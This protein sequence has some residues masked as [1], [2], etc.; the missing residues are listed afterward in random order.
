MSCRRVETAVR[1]MSTEAFSRFEGELFHSIFGLI[2]SPVL[3]DKLGGVAAL[4]ALINASTCQAEIKIIKFS[5]NLS[6][7]LRSN[8]NYDLLVQVSKALGHM[9]SSRVV[10]NADFVEFEIDRGLEWLRAEQWR[11]RLAACL[12]LK[13]LAANTP[14][15]FYGKMGDFLQRITP[16]L[17]D[18][19]VNVRIASTEAVT[20]CLQILA[21]RRLRYHLDWLCGIYD[22]LQEGM[23]RASEAD[24]HGAL[25]AVEAMLKHCKD[26]MG[27]RFREVCEGVM[28]FRQHKSRLVRSTLTSLLPLLADF[29]PDGFALLYLEDSVEFLF[30]ACKHAESRGAA[31]L[32]LGKLALA[33]GP[34][35]QPKLPEM[36]EVAMIGLVPK[37]KLRRSFCTEV[38]PFLSDLV[39]SLR[40]AMSP[41]IG[42]LLEPMFS[43]GIS[44]PLTETLTAVSTYLPG[45]R[46]KV[47]ERL[48]KELALYLTGEEYYPPGRYPPWAP[49]G[50][51]ALVVMPKL[52]VSD[53]KKK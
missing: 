24:V 21:E 37:K 19:R 15:T 53:D 11:R 40:E 6:N 33:V 16:L 42:Q 23:H 47:Q 17:R 5:N 4:D 13:E 36:I 27:P 41:Y 20:M 22:H 3:K 52:Q 18:G 38:L 10:P 1:E 30:A 48:L 32:A 51:D 12:V 46:L 9:A 39:M 49:R 25:L 28:P 35:L 34:H 44:E 14:T 43:Q 2:R 29:S 8:T 26:F 7:A 50:R 45:H 31:Y